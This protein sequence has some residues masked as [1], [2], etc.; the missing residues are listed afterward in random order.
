[1]PRPARDSNPSPAPAPTRV[2]IARIA[3]PRGIKGEV[4]ADLLTDFPERLTQLKRVYLTP[5]TGR[6][7]ERE[8]TVARCW[9]HQGRAVFQFAGIASVEAAEKLRDMDVQIPLSERV[10]L[11][12]GK[13]FVSDLVGCAVLEVQQGR[14]T[15]IGVIRDVTTEAGAPLLVVDSPRGELLIPFAEDICKRV[16]LEARCVEIAA[17]EGLLDLNE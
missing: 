1:V 3:R 2:T 13:Y 12:A 16:D 14:P 15:P 8:E 11:P 6:G 4:V 7:P 9:L 5:S 17:P 10:T